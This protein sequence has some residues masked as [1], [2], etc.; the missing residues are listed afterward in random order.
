LYVEKILYVN[1][2]KERESNNTFC[3]LLCVT[4]SEQRFH[5][6][7]EIFFLSFEHDHFFLFFG[8]QC[9]GVTIRVKFTTERSLVGPYFQTQK[10]ENITTEEISSRRI[11]RSVVTPVSG[12]HNERGDG[13]MR[14]FGLLYVSQIPNQVQR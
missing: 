7:S 5:D 10:F 3:W 4:S 8:R 1:D 13:A 12:E 6:I 11:R 9:H 14:S 2:Q